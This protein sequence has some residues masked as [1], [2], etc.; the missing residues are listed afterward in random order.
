MSAVGAVGAQAQRNRSAQV[1]GVRS[2]LNSGWSFGSTMGWNQLQSIGRRSARMPN[3]LKGRRRAMRAG[4]DKGASLWGAMWDT[5]HGAKGGASLGS[6]YL[7]QTGSGIGRWAMGMDQ[8]KFGLGKGAAAAG[9]RMGAVGLG[10]AALDFINPF[11]FG[12]ND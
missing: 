8:W 12:W 7:R 3:V 4:G 5:K 9:A 11:G 10:F 1:A 6:Q 2:G